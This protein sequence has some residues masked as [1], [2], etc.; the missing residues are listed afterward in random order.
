MA[1]T[2]GET[3][4]TVDHTR[5]DERWLDRNV[6][7]MTMASFLSDVGHEMATS[8]PAFLAALSVP[9]SALGLIEGLADAA[10]SF[11]KLGAGWTSDRLGRRKT[12]VVGGYAL[13]GASQAIFALAWGW[14]I[15]LVGRVVGWFGRGV[16]GP[17]R[18]AM[19]AE[20]VP[21]AHR[22]KA[23][24]LHRAGDTL[25]AVTG[26]LVAMAMVSL[27]HHGGPE[28][29]LRVFRVVFLLTAVPGLLS[30]AVFFVLVDERRRA[31]NPGLALGTA[32]R[33]LPPALRRALVG[34]GIFGLGDF[35][36][37]LIILAAVE[38]LTPASGAVHAAAIGGLLYV[39]HNAAYAVAPF[40]VGALGDRLGRRR[41]LSIGYALGVAVSLALG[42][43]LATRTANVVLL[44]AIFASAG[45]VLGVEDA[46]EAPLVADFVG[47][48]IGGTSQGVLGTV[49]GIGDLVSSVV[50]G[51]LWSVHPLLGFGYA[52]LA[53]GAGAVLVQCVR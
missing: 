30:A 15:V 1:G 23:F 33:A 46:L 17:L 29:A 6:V 32:L 8:M 35:S 43:A 47:P 48:E 26:P 18:D 13:T 9:P 38:L 53:M 4:P 31:P 14:P 34:I 11:I 28:D 50:V 27:L 36:H 22:G 41:L 40:P 24:G 7:G 44:A 25:G 21:R 2:V 37:T 3:A 10:A 45:L 12:I 39:L 49:N 20:S 5:A 16:R 52:A 19:L 51:V 42:M